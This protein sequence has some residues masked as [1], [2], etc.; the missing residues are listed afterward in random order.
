MRPEGAAAP[1][2][3][4]FFTRES[5]T[6]LCYHV[7]GGINL[8]EVPSWHRVTIFRSQQKAKRLPDKHSP[9]GR[10]H[11]QCAWSLSALKPISRLKSRHSEPAVPTSSFQQAHVPTVQILLQQQQ[12][13]ADQ[14][15]G[16]KALACPLCLLIGL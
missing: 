8:I 1:A 15:I 2:K 12:H 9:A 11:K 5:A 14:N 3:A 7:Q 10:V 6:G 13:C 16:N 4:E